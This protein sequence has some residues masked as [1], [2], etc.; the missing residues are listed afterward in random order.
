MDFGEFVTDFLKPVFNDIN[1]VLAPL[2]PIIDF[3]K[4]PTPLIKDIAPLDALLKAI[5]HQWSRYAAGPHRGGRHSDGQRITAT[6]H[7]RHPHASRQYQRLPRHSSVCSM[8]AASGSIGL[9]TFSFGDFDLRLA[10]GSGP[11]ALPTTINATVLGQLAAGLTARD[12]STTH[13]GA[14][15]AALQNDEP[16]FKFPLLS[17]PTSLVQLLFGQ[18]IVLVEYDLPTISV[19]YTL[20]AA[21]IGPIWPIPPVSIVLGGIGRSDRRRGIWLRYRRSSRLRDQRRCG[22]PHQRLLCRR[23]TGPRSHLYGRCHGRCIRRHCR[24]A[25][26]NRCT[27][28]RRHYRRSEARSERRGGLDWRADRTTV[29][30]TSTNSPTILAA[31]SRQPVKSASR[32]CWTSY[33][34]RGC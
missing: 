26:T 21:K 29:A 8:T 11:G 16:G 31:F 23:Q 33:C 19:G 6:E 13:E 24:W 30:S 5:E 22:R 34:R 2:A 32:C 9:G 12:L 20:R 10:A 15:R 18:D 27:D 17:D 28:H 1:E 3:L 4:S 25:C 7:R 14:E